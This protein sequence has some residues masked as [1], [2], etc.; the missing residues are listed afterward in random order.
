[1]SKTGNVRPT[2]TSNCLACVLRPGGGPMTESLI[3]VTRAAIVAATLAAGCADD[4]D[5]G[6]EGASCG[7]GA[8]ERNGACIPAPACGEGTR[9]D[10]GTDS[11][12][13]GDDVCSAGTILVGDHCVA[14]DTGLDPDAVEA[15]E[16]NDADVAGTI[17]VPDADAAD[18]FIAY[19]CVEPRDPDG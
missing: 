11:C 18:P 15:E 3:R 7:D 17:V 9:L 12:V 4:G 16:P 19:G 14:V 13:P 8:V 10:P 1:D 6:G 5:G 2:P